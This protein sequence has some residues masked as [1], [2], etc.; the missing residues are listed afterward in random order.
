MR[1]ALINPTVEGIKASE[2]PLNLGY[3]A[4]YLE[5]NGIEVKIIDQ[6]AGDDVSREINVYSPDI[7]GITSMTAMVVEAYRIADMC[8]RIGILTVMGGEHPSAMP[9]EAL[10]H[11][12][13][14][15]VGEGEIAMLDI[16]KE[17]ITSGIVSRASLKDIDELPLFPWRLIK[18]D[19]YLHMTNETKLATLAF[20]GS[21]LSSTKVTCFLTSRGCPFRCIFC[22]NSLSLRQS[23]VRFHSAERV[24]E[25]IRRLKADYGVEAIAFLDENFLVNKPR[26]EEICHKMIEEKLGILWSCASSAHFVDL[27]TTRMIQ[28][29]GCRQV[30]FG[31]ESGSQ[32]ILD[33]LGKS[34]TV[35]QNKEAIKICKEAGLLIHGSF[36]LGSPTETV[37]DVRL[38]Q[39]FILESNIESYRINITTPYPGTKLWE[40]CNKQIPRPVNWRRFEA[41]NLE[42]YPYTTFSKGKLV[43]LFLE[44]SLVKPAIYQ[45]DW[46]PAPRHLKESIC[47]LLRHPL[48]AAKIILGKYVMRKNEKRK[49]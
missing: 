7:V 43:R 31:L 21:A 14:V 9:E 20:L 44:A 12:D 4:G 49:K 13:V 22:H 15:V 45:R 33:V 16:V 3:I 34:T 39:K 23:P 40:L 46:R 27:K 19:S 17:R 41:G 38:T 30:A 29:A 5:Q 6:M 25:E 11:A 36:M 37:E 18:L 28:E 47:W 8:R 32:R 35:E 10:E 48:T 1:V 26:L 24:L 2:V 42:V